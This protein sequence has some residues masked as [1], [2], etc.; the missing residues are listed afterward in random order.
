MS[1]RRDRAQVQ[2]PFLQVEDDESVVVG[3]FASH[4]KR[5]GRNKNSEG[6]G[7]HASRLVLDSCQFI[8]RDFSIVKIKI[9]G[10]NRVDFEHKL[11]HEHQ[12]QRYL[13]G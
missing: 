8:Q 12:C 5:C 9:V 10:K 1:G 11:Q 2:R 4:S 13:T 3:G 6:D 7:E